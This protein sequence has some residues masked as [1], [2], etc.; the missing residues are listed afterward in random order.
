MGSPAELAGL[1]YTVVRPGGL[2]EDPSLESVEGLELNQGDTKSGRIARADVANIC[3]E[4]LLYPELTS[5]TTFECYYADTGA[6]LASVG[7][8]NIF[9]QKTDK[10]GFVSGRECRGSS[11]N[12]LFSGLEKD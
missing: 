8:S 4:A 9:K 1:S 11:W 5:R 10:D 6:P 7:V 12:E 2:T 3:V